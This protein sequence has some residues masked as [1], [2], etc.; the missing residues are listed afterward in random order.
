MF[1]LYTCVRDVQ[2]NSHSY[3]VTLPLCHLIQD[4]PIGLRSC[5]VSKS[6]I[7]NFGERN[8]EDVTV[9]LADQQV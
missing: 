9:T 8:V 5:Q 6:F 2:Y 7:H 3:H 1:L 4:C